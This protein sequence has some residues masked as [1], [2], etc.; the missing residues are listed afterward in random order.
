VLI[1]GGVASSA[2]LRQLL[3]ARLK[4]QDVRIGVHWGRPELSGDNACGV[5]LIGDE[6]RKRG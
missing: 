6:K 3:P 2:L 1:S 5:A 4:K